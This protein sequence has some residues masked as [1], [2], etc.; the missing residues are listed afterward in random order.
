MCHCAWPGILITSSEVA[1]EGKGSEGSQVTADRGE[2]GFQEYPPSS[3]H[4]GFLTLTTQKEAH[5]GTKSGTSSSMVWGDRM[6]VAGCTWVQ[7]TRCCELVAFQVDELG[8][9]LPWD[10]EHGDRFC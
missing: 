10:P 9:S 4:A 2:T 6:P 8:L 3:L 7:E 5:L 1:S